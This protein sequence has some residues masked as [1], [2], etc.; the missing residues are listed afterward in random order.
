M[1][2]LE[3]PLC[4]FEAPQ[5]PVAG[6]QSGLYK[7]SHHDLLRG[8]ESHQCSQQWCRESLK[9]L[10][11]AE[12]RVSFI[13]LSSSSWGVGMNNRAELSFKELIYWW[14]NIYSKQVYTW[15]NSATC[16]KF[17]FGRT[18]GMWKFL[19][20]RWN[21]CHGSHLS[22]CSDNA[23]SWTRCTTKKKKTPGFEKKIEWFDRKKLGVVGNLLWRVVRESF[24]EEVTFG[25]SCEGWEGWGLSCRRVWGGQFQAEE[26]AKCKGPEFRKSQR[27]TWTR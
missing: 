17:F 20:Q 5:T 13:E 12:S 16:V 1:S 21:P 24:L 19:G 4:S 14:G 8:S 22:H 15:T 27:V 3:R 25:L 26:I 6:W 7:Y 10:R 9:V 2:I 18:Q 11:P 23:G